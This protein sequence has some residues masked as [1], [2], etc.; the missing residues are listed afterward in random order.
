MSYFKH[1]T[2]IVETTQIGEGTKIWA[3]SHVQELVFEYYTLI[4]LLSVVRSDIFYFFL[5]NILM[6]L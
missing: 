2:S 4:Y 1:Q 3:F 5:K 6:F